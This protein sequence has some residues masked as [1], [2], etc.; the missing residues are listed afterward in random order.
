MAGI[1]FL[2]S[3][4]SARSQLAE[5]IARHLAPHL[6]IWS[7]GSHPSHVQ[8][9]V[10]RV[11]DEVDIDP[12]GLRSKGIETAVGARNGRQTPEGFVVFP[13]ASIWHSLIIERT[14]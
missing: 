7:A 5:A 3:A 2:C 9:E 11:L 13:R 1:L 4:N 6:D 8:P 10:R 14:A 12:R